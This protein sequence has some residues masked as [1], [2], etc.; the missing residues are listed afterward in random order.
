MIHAL[1][2]NPAIALPNL[3]TPSSFEPVVIGIAIIILV[4]LL[5]V[6]LRRYLKR[7]D[8]P[9]DDHDS[10]SSQFSAASSHSPTS[11]ALPPFPSGTACT[12]LPAPGP[13]QQPP[14]LPA[15]VVL[16]SMPRPG[17]LPDPSGNPDVIRYWN[18][19]AWTEYT[20]ERCG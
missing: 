16:P 15:T 2:G 19:A 11:D 3:R 7:S 10:S 9:I 13:Y 5:V 8:A 12:D 1:D 14:A 6:L 4:V 18:G 20:A 17:W